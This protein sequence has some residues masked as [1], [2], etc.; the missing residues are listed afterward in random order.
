MLASEE[1][2]DRKIELVERALVKSGSLDESEEIG[3][4]SISEQSLS[5]DGEEVEW[6]EQR[7][8]RR[9]RTLGSRI[10]LEDEMLT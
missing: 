9:R 4:V 8:V 1:K 3:G 2:T 7:S 5:S 10:A 6:E